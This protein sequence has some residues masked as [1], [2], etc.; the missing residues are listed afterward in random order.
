AI[1]IL[2]SPDI[3]SITPTQRA[4]GVTGSTITVYGSGAYFQSGLS[5]WFSTF[6]SMEAGDADSEVTV[7]AGNI[8]DADASVIYLRDVDVTG[9]AQ[10]GNR[11]LI[12]ENPD[13]GKSITLSSVLTVEP[14]L[15]LTAQGI[16]VV[17]SATDN[18]LGQNVT[19]KTI[20]VTGAGFENGISDSDIS[21]DV[22]TSSINVKSV[23]WKSG[24][25]IELLVDVS[26]LCP[27]GVT[28]LTVTNPDNG[29]TASL[30]AADYF[31]VGAMPLISQITSPA[32]K[33]YGQLAD[34]DGYPAK[35]FTVEGTGF[36]SGME[37][38][39]EDTLITVSNELF[40]GTT[41]YE[42]D[43]IIGSNFSPAEEGGSLV[44]VT[45]VNP[46]LGQ[47]VLSSTITINP[48]PVFTSLDVTSGGQGA[49]GSTLT[50]TGTGL[51]SGAE[52]DFGVGVSTYNAYYHSSSSFTV[53]VDISATAATGKRNV[54][55]R[56]PDLG[57]GVKTSYFDVKNSPDVDYVS[58]A[59][60]APGVS[61]STITV[62]GD[63]A[64]FQS[65]YDAWFSTSSTG[66]PADGEI[67]IENKDFTSVSYVELQ[68]VNITGSALLGDRYIVV[69][70]P[71]GGRSVSALS[72]L[73]IQALPTLT[74]SGISVVGS[75]SSNQLGQNTTEKTIKITGTG[76]ENGIG[77]SDITFDVTSDSITIQSVTWKSSGLL[78][79][80]LDVS[81]G[82]PV[83]NR[84]VTV[85]NPLSGGSDSRGDAGYF[86][87]GAMPV[88][89]TITLPVL[90]EYGQTANTVNYPLKKFTMQGSGFISDLKL[91]FGLNEITQN[92]ALVTGDTQF[93][94]DLTIDSNFSPS[95]S[96]VN[97]RIVNPD[98]GEYT[99]PSAMI[100]N[101]K[102]VF[103]S[104]SVIKAGQGTQGITIVV[105][106]SALQENAT[107]DF[108]VGISTSGAGYDYTDIPS[109]FTVTVDLS[110]SVIV[111]QKDVT[112]RNPDLGYATKT[113][114]F[115]ITGKPEVDTVTPAKRA[116][117]VSG[118]TITV[119]GN[120][121]YFQTGFDIW[122]STDSSGYPADTKI[123]TGTLNGFTASSF[124]LLDFN[125]EADAQLGDRYMAV[126]NPDGGLYVTVSKAMEI[127]AAPTLTA[128]GLVVNGATPPN[129]LGQNV[130]NI[131]LSINGSGFESN[132]E[133]DTSAVYFDVIAP[134]ITVVNV[135][136]I[137]S[138]LIDVYVDVSSNCELGDRTVYVENPDSGG[139][140]SMSDAG[141]FTIG[142][143]P[144]IST[145]TLP[146]LKEY[147]QKADTAG[148][149]AKRFTVE[150]TGFVSNLKL[151]FGSYEITQ[152]DPQ[153]LNGGTTFYC[154]LTIDSNMLVGAKDVKIV[155]PD[156]G[157][158]VL[159][160]AITINTK[161]VLTS[162]SPAYLGQGA[163]NEQIIVVCSS[164]NFQS[165][166]TLSFPDISPTQYSFHTYDY[167][168]GVSSFT[169]LLN[170]DLDA[171]SGL[172]NVRLDNPDLGWSS[173][174]NGFDVRKNPTVASIT[175]SDV[176][177]G[178][179]T[180][181][182][183][184]RTIDIWGVE[185]GVF[186]E[187][188]LV[189]IS[190]DNMA[191]PLDT[192]IIV[193]TV[194]YIG[195]NHLEMDLIVLT[196][197]AWSPGGTPDRYLKL[198]NPDGGYYISG[199]KLLTVNKPPVL[200]TVN[201]GTPNNNDLGQ[202]A[203]D[204]SIR[205]E[206][207]DFQS[208]ATVEINSDVDIHVSNI[209]FDDPD[210]LFDVD[211]DDNAA[212]NASTFTV[213]N[214]DGG[215]S[216]K[217]DYSM[218]HVTTKP[219]VTAVTSPS[220]E[221]YGQGAIDAIILVSGSD[222]IDGIGT[223][224]V[225]FSGT[226]ITL[227]GVSVTPT[228]LT[229][230]VDI[231]ETSAPV[232]SSRTIT[233]INPDFGADVSD[234]PIF[235][236][237]LNPDI[238]SI[239]P[240]TRGQGGQD[241]EL[242]LFGSSFQQGLTVTPTHIDDDIW[243]SGS[244]I[245]I[246]SVTHI[247]VDGS[248]VTVTINITDNASTS[249][250]RSITVRNPDKGRNTFNVGTFVG[251]KPTVGTLDI[252]EL[253]AGA[254]VT[255]ITVSGTGFAAGAQA[256]FTTD[257]GGS[258]EET[259]ITIDSVSGSGEELYLNT[260][261]V[262][263]ACLGAKFLKVINPDGGTDVSDNTVLTVS[264]AP[265][266][267]TVSPTKLGQQAASRDITISGTNFDINTTISDVTFIP[268]E[269]ITKNSIDATNAEDPGNNR[270]IVNVSV[271]SDAA[272]GARDV[273]IINPN[274][275]SNTKAGGLE[276]TSKPTFSMASPSSLGRGA[277]FEDI[278]IT[279]ANFANGMQVYFSGGSGI[280]PNPA[281]A[282]GSATSMSITVSV[283]TDATVTSDWGIKVENTDFG[284]DLVSSTFTVTQRPSVTQLIP[285][286][287]GPG[288][289]AQDILVKG[290]NFQSGL[291]ATD[292]TFSHGGGGISVTDIFYHGVSSFT[293]RINVSQ[294]C[295]TSLGNI[296]IENPDKG[297]ITETDVFTVNDKPVV[298]SCTPSERSKDL[299]NQTIIITG[300]GF[301]IA[302]SVTRAV[303]FGTTSVQAV[304]A[305]NYLNDTTLE[306][307][308]TIYS[309]AGAQG[310]D[311]TVVN[312]DGGVG[313]GSSIFTVN[314]KPSITSLNLPARGQGA[315]NQDIRVNGSD[316]QSGSTVTISGTGVNFTSTTF[317]SANQL[318]IIVNIDYDATISTRDVS[319]L[320][321]DAGTFIF[322]SS[323][324]VHD[325]PVTS[326]GA[327]WLQF[328]NTDL[329]ES[330]GT[331][332]TDSQS[333]SI[334]IRQLSDG[335]WY[336]QGVGFTESSEEWLNADY[337]V[338]DSTWSYTLPGLTDGTSYYVRTF[339]T[340]QNAGREQAGSGVTF[341]HDISEPSAAVT[342]PVHLDHYNASNNKL[343]SLEGTA[344]ADTDYVE[345]SI[346]DITRGTTY[347]D[348]AA[349]IT[350]GADYY[351][352][353]ND[354]TPES[355]SY[356]FSTENWTNAN[357]Y[358]I[359]AQAIDIAGNT[360][361][362]DSKDFWIDYEYPV[363][364]VTI[365]SA[366][367]FNNFTVF[368][369]P[370]YDALPDQESTT[371]SDVEIYIF[372]KADSHYFDETDWDAA[373]AVWIPIPSEN[374]DQDSWSYDVP[375]PTTTFTD[376]YGNDDYDIKVR[377]IDKAVNKECSD[378][379][380]SKTEKVTITWDD[381]PPQ[382]S[383]D[384]PEEADSINYATMT[385]SG[386]VTELNGVDYIALSIYN[387][388]TVQWWTGGGWTG[389][390]Q[391][392]QV[393]PAQ[394]F[395][396]SWTYSGVT[397][398]SG[399]YV[400]QTKGKDLIGPDDNIETPS[401]GR[402]F[403]FDATSP[404]TNSVTIPVHGDWYNDTMASYSG[405]AVDDKSGIQ[406]VKL[407]IQ[408]LTRG[409]TFWNGSNWV[410]DAAENTFGLIGAPYNPWTYSGAEFPT[411]IDNHTYEITPIAKDN[412]GNQ[413]TGSAYRY[414]YDLNTP[415]SSITF[416]QDGGKYG[417]IATITGE[418]YDK[419]ID[420]DSIDKVEVEIYNIDT[421][422]YFQGGASWLNS[423][424][425]L[426]A[427]LGTW[428]STYTLRNWSYSMPTLSDDDNY[429]I[430]SRAQ[431]KSG[432]Y[433]VA[434]D[435]V[436]FLYSAAVPVSI[437]TMPKD[438]AIFYRDIPLARGESHAGSG[439]SVTKVEID[440][441][442]VEDETYKHWNWGDTQWETTTYSD[443]YWTECSY[444]ASNKE[445][446]E[447]DLSVVN[448][449]QVADDK[450]IVIRVRAT[451][452][453]DTESAG[454]GVSVTN[455]ADDDYALSWIK[456]ASLSHGNVE[457]V[458][459]TITVSGI[460]LLPT[461]G[462]LAIQKI[463]PSGN[464]GDTYDLNVDDVYWQW[465]PET[466]IATKD[467]A[468]GT[469]SGD[470]GDWQFELDVSS[471]G[472]GVDWESDKYYR[473]LSK[474]TNAQG[475]ESHHAGTVII[476]D[477]EGPDSHVSAALNGTSFKDLDSISG[478]AQDAVSGVTTDGVEVQVK[479]LLA[480][481]TYYWDGG[482]V[483]FSSTTSNQWNTGTTA[484]A[485][486][487]VTANWSYVSSGVNWG[488]ATV[489]TLLSRAIDKGNNYQTAINAGP[490]VTC[491]R[492]GPSS[493]V[494]YPTTGK[495]LNFIGISDFTVSGSA[496]D[497]LSTVSSA[498]IRVFRNGSYLQ[499]NF[500]WNAADNWIPASG[501]TDWSVDL[502]TDVWT[503]DLVSTITARATDN[504][505]NI[506]AES[507]PVWF[508]Y[509]DEAPVSN[510]NKPDGVHNYNDTVSDITDYIH[511]DV[512]DNNTYDKVYVRIQ[513]GVLD[514]YWDDVADD[515]LSGSEHWNEVEIHQS[516][517][518]YT[519]L[520]TWLNQWNY[521]VW[522][523]AVDIAS[524]VEAAGSYNQF[525]F[526]N[527]D[528]ESRITS[529]SASSFTGTPPNIAGTSEDLETGIKD[530][531]I[532]LKY[533]DS[534]T[535][536]YWNTV[537]WDT[538]VEWMNSDDPSVSP[539]S[540]SGEPD[541]TDLE[542]GR[543]YK[544]VSQAADTKGPEAPPTGNLNMEDYSANWVDF[545]WDI[546][547]PTAVVT[548]PANNG[549]IP[550]INDISGTCFDITGATYSVPGV[551]T[552]S[553][554]VAEVQL[555]LWKLI[556]ST[557]Y[558]W[559][560]FAMQPNTWTVAVAWSTA[561]LS[562]DATSWILPHPVWETKEYKVVVRARDAGDNYQVLVNTITFK[563]DFINPESY[564]TNPVD[565]TKYESMNTITGTASDE[566][567]LEKIKIKIVND[568]GGDDR[569][570]YCW[571][572]ITWT[573]TNPYWV[574]A[575]FTDWPDWSYTID[576]PT[577]AWEHGKYYEVFTHAVDKANNEETTEE[578]TRNENRFL[579]NDQASSFRVTIET[580]PVAGV[581][582]TMTVDAWDNVNNNVA[583]AYRGT[584][585]FRSPSGMNFTMT[586]GT[587]TFVEGDNGSHTFSVGISSGPLFRTPEGAGTFE[588]YDDE[589]YAGEISSMVA[590]NLIPNDLNHFD[591]T[592][593]PSQVTAGTEYDITVTARDVYNN[594]K[595]N[596][597]GFV[598]FAS[599][600]PL[601]TFKDNY[602]FI[603]G[604]AGE[605]LFPSTV[606]MRT[607]NVGPGNGST[608]WW[609]R[610]RD[611]GENVE[612]YA[613]N[614]T[615]YPKSY[616]AF[617]VSV[618]TGPLTA[619][620]ATDIIVEAIDDYG[621]RCSTGSVI[622]D[623][624]VEF[625]SSDGSAV[626]PDDYTFTT[627]SGNDNG[628]H[629]FTSSLTL[630]TVGTHWFKANDTIATGKSG[631]QN[632]IEVDPATRT[633][634]ELIMSTDQT[635]GIAFSI[636]VMAKDQYGNID[637]NN[638]DFVQFVTNNT[639]ATLPLISEQLVSGEK[640]WLNSF[641]LRAA[642]WTLAGVLTQPW[643]IE[644]QWENNPGVINGRKENI[645]ITP[646]PASEFV[647]S[648]VADPIGAGDP[649]A[650]FVEA[651][652]EYGNR[653]V[654]YI[655]T[656]T[657]TSDSPSW[658][659]V[660]A[661]YTFL[662]SDRG[663]K[664]FSATFN[665]ASP[666]DY[667]LE[668]Y[669][670]IPSSPTLNGQFPGITVN[671]S[672]FT[673]LTITGIDDPETEGHISQSVIVTARDQFNNVYTSY[674]STVSFS[675]LTDPG[676]TASPSQYWYQPGD[677]GIHTFNITMTEPGEHDV[678]VYD[679]ITPAKDGYQYNVTVTTKPL[680]NRTQP[681]SAQSSFPYYK[682]LTQVQ[683]T[684]F[685]YDPAQISTVN[686]RIYD[687]TEN[688]YWDEIQT[689]WTGNEYWNLTTGTTEWIYNTA[690]WPSQGDYKINTVAYDDLTGDETLA[691]TTTT[692]TF[693][694]VRPNTIIENPG[695]GGDYQYID[696]FSGTSNDASSPMDEV[697]IQIQ[698]ITR[699]TT[700]WD[701]DNS[702]W[703]TS[704]LWIDKNSVQAVLGA[705]DWQWNSSLVGWMDQHQY[706]IT[707]QAKDQAGNWDDLTPAISN[708]TIDEDSP[709][710]SVA[711][712]V[713]GRNYYSIP[714]L[715]GAASDTQGINRVRIMIVRDS[716]GFY[717]DPSAGTWDFINSFT[718]FTVSGQDSW[719]WNS[720][721]VTFVD[722]ITYKVKSI[723]IDEAENTENYVP[724]GFN[725]FIF[726]TDEST[727]AV[728]SPSISNVNTA[729]GAF[730]VS[731]TAG[732][733]DSDV[734]G[735]QIV[736]KRDQGAGSYWD[737]QQDDWV[738]GIYWNNITGTDT[739]SYPDDP[740][741]DGIQLVDGV[742]HRIWTRSWDNA[743]PGGTTEQVL[744]GDIDTN[745]NEKQSF[746]Y[747]ITK[748]SSSITYPVDTAA[749]NIQIETFTGS[750][751]D[752]KTGGLQ[753]SEV[754]EVRLR[755]KRK[756]DG[757]YWQHPGWGAADSLATVEDV[758]PGTETFEWY[759]T[760]AN[761]GAVYSAQTETY[762]I[763]VKAKD[764]ADNYESGA[765]W[766]NVH[767]SSATERKATF[768]YDMIAPAIS[769]STP[770][771][772]SHHNQLTEIG[773]ISS[774]GYSGVNNVKVNISSGAYSWTGS[775]WTSNTEW[776]TATGTATWK[777]T[778]LTDA[779]I[780]NNKYM[781]TGRVWDNASNFTSAIS[782]FV[783]DVNE[784]TASVVVP[785]SGEP[786]YTTETLPAFFTGNS[787]DTAP[788]QPQNTIVALENI[789]AGKY[790]NGT[791]W[792]GG[793]TWSNE[794]GT[795]D[796][797]TGAA[798]WQWATSDIT[799]WNDPT[800]N[801]KHVFYAKAI[802]EAGNE[803]LDVNIS[804]NIFWFQGDLP[805][806]I[807]TKP[808][809][810]NH[811]NWAANGLLSIE[812]TYEFCDEV[813]IRIYRNND[814]QCW[815]QTGKV[816]VSSDT[817]E[818]W[819]VKSVADDEWT[820]SIDTTAW[821]SGDTYLV[822]SR[823]WAPTMGNE[824][825]YLIKAQTNKNITID[826]QN[827][828][829]SVTSPENGSFLNSASEID[830][831][832]SDLLAGIRD[833]TVSLQDDS[834][835]KY[836]D[837]T[838]DDW[839]DP[840]AWSTTVYVAGNWSFV[841][842]PSL[843]QGQLYRIKPKARDDI[844]EG[845]GNFNE[846]IGSEITFTYDIVAPTV[847]ITSPADSSFPSAISTMTGTSTD[848][849]PIELIKLQ[850]KN[851]DATT[852]WKPG[853]GGGWST[854]EKWVTAAGT[855]PWTYDATPIGFLEGVD[856][857]LTA[858]AI[859]EA[860]STSTIITNNFT[861]DD[862]EPNSVI[863][864]PADAYLTDTDL[865]INGIYGNASDNVSGIDDD[866]V[867]NTLYDIT[868]DSYWNG[869]TWQ[870][871]VSTLT[872]SLQWEADYILP[873]MW[874]SAHK[875]TIT[876]WVS[877]DKAIPGNVQ[878]SP[879]TFEVVVDSVPPVSRTTTPSDG[880][881][882][883]ALSLIEGTCYDDWASV[884]NDWAANPME[885]EIKALANAPAG[886]DDNEYWKGSTLEWTTY[887]AVAFPDVYISSWSYN[888]TGSL[889]SGREY[890][891]V[892]SMTDRV[893][894]TQIDI[895][896]VTVLI[897]TD[898]P[899]SSFQEPIDPTNGNYFNDI[900]QIT[901]ITQDEP[902]APSNRSGLSLIELQLID[903]TDSM[904]WEGST[905]TAVN[906]WVPA[907]DL[908][909]W[910]YNIDTQTDTWENNHD[911]TF[912]TR[913]L[914]IAGNTESP[915]GDLSL[916]F[917]DENPVSAVT[918]PFDG[919]YV[920][921][922]LSITSGTISDNK[923]GV[924]YVEVWIQ[925]VEGNYYKAADN[926]FTSGVKVWNPVDT[927]PGDS[928]WSLTVATDVWTDGASYIVQSMAYDAAT[929]VDGNSPN[930]E[931]AVA[932]ITFIY[933]ESNPESEVVY[934]STENHTIYTN[935]TPQIIGT[936][937]DNAPG[938]IKT[939]KYSIKRQDTKYWDGEDW[940]SGSEVWVDADATSADF[941][942]WKATA[943]DWVKDV[944]YEVKSKAYDDADN[945]E[946]AFM[947]TVSSFVYDTELPTSTP[948]SPVDE[949]YVDVLTD[950]S[951]TAA[952]SGGS[953]VRTVRTLIIDI[954][955]A[956]T[957][958]WSG[959]ALDWQDTE[960][961]PWPLA[962]GK[963]SW[964]YSDFADSDMTDGHRYEIKVKAQD[965]ATNEQV[966]TIQ[967]F[968]YDKA[969]PVSKVTIPVN[970]FY[971]ELNTISGTAKDTPDS[972]FSAGVN[973][974]D[975]MIADRTADPDDYWTG[976]EWSTSTIDF[977]AAAGSTTWT[978]DASG[979]GL[980]WTDAHVYDVIPR[981]TDQT[982]NVEQSFSTVTFT[983]DDSDPT[984]VITN[985]QTADETKIQ[986]I[987]EGTAS[988]TPAQVTAVEIKIEDRT[989]VGDYW[990]GST[991]T[992]SV[993]WLP[994]NYTG[995]GWDY[996]IV[997]TDT[998][999]DGHLYKIQSRAY[1000]ES[1001]NVED[1002]GTSGNSFTYDITKPQSAQITIQNN[1003]YEKYLDQITGSSTDEK[1004][1005]V[1006]EARVLVE[1007]DDIPELYW[1008][1009]PGKVWDTDPVWNLV[1010]A[1011]NAPF[1012][1013]NDEDWTIA[1014]A[1015]YAWISGGRVS[1016]ES[1017]RVYTRATDDSTNEET[1018]G[1019][1020]VYFT[1021]DE[1022]EP[1023]SI[1024]TD[1025]ADGNTY[1026]QITA[1027]GG[1028][1029]N[1030]DETFVS[1031]V[1032]ISIYDQ[1033]S[1034]LYS[1035]GAGGWGGSVD[1036]LNT[1037][1038]YTS[1039]WTFAA[1040]ALTSDHNYRIVSRA[1041]DAALNFETTLSTIIF[1042]YDDEAPTS[1043]ITSPSAG[1044][1045]NS[1046]SSIVGNS[1047]DT[1048][1049]GIALAQLRIQ[1050]ITAGTSY[1051]T[1052]VAWSTTSVWQDAIGD[1053]SWT[1054]NNVPDWI[1055]GHQVT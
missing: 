481:D 406:E 140:V 310:Y 305:V 1005:G 763:E 704:A 562:G 172:R 621:N 370:I 979:A 467:W 767:W 556:G 380:S 83:G 623:D 600:E 464:D 595:T 1016:G 1049:S 45:L 210:I 14:E 599:N 753:N 945:E 493:T 855:D 232:I 500:T 692:F 100:I 1029:F 875:Y 831:D 592:S 429:R 705:A 594:K 327:P 755:I 717:F 361:D 463:T 612:K 943:T 113:D 892:S 955:G 274:Y 567:E 634:Y 184:V 398:E 601:A 118:S 883:K 460:G 826:N 452:T 5:V 279:G 355:W 1013:S 237:N 817:A 319:V 86:V 1028:T 134:S 212:I 822:T 958:Y 428:I 969:K 479:Y 417:G 419:P 225:E 171:D 226:G 561:T 873:G 427:A 246:S 1024:I 351:F 304:S 962:A 960:P 92:N 385:L 680:S 400:V 421:G 609:I 277:T 144:L 426:E 606:T 320:N 993:I 325:N 851:K 799:L 716:D 559:D 205:I 982:G 98:F 523:Y 898:D 505:T 912:K 935:I 536:Y 223:D 316:F 1054:Y 814:D 941:T 524:N 786:N 887:T 59:V 217:S 572:G 491:D 1033:N 526:D 311:V 968:Y 663:K 648:G 438:G 811:Y 697:K 775:S 240:T 1015:S 537:N 675:C 906:T 750:F 880:N 148:N 384:F 446:W 282:A 10:L 756:S 142:Q 196:T 63:G 708:I 115:E 259:L 510:V 430:V 1052:G 302:G 317:I 527:M 473:I 722:G 821:D 368:S 573:V 618:D 254:S 27:T 133:G 996:N 569:Q 913:G 24:S 591:I 399:D 637:T 309:T 920:K 198:V 707:V 829:V 839:D 105:N 978:Y 61:G 626:I 340:G 203:S 854:S 660:F 331:A 390:Q 363:S 93:E 365:P 801:E 408:N 224:D 734:A 639:D 522:S 732:D 469:I 333:V 590:L 72:V 949:S 803:Q 293:A 934:I 357:K 476:I 696:L 723:A 159:S 781:I 555:K 535:T 667:Y 867:E 20:K 401:A 671:P 664:S 587:Y 987:I 214:P 179:G 1039:S 1025:P 204:I 1050:D 253:G 999:T 541:A 188:C 37:L 589:T 266:I 485:A 394:L 967:H 270:I 174:T 815:D 152:D 33:E 915:S 251:L 798:S 946:S 631:Q 116:R 23:T 3:N 162:L 583:T 539:W 91:Y 287:L 861:F 564:L 177:R 486:G 231:A 121:P 674:D 794:S 48:K 848:G 379:G 34:T 878:T 1023:D 638:G 402:N 260:V 776:L 584:V 49:V 726:D 872:T 932:S 403:S 88:I 691:Y 369:G 285:N 603:L 1022:I 119:I 702:T 668:A 1042:T 930:V 296:T 373:S 272:T 412:S 652:D 99:L 769:M 748:P 1009:E 97:V 252:D 850:I 905:W 187:G 543:I 764:N 336:K 761:L 800:V 189:Y 247:A 405:A 693:D 420:K 809:N 447:K 62:Y 642:S 128:S 627:G 267:N 547:V 60:R 457:S 236:V 879:D 53:Q 890:V 306:V 513:K 32:V 770:I 308:V 381:T 208:G 593:L 299:A 863:I 921:P 923:S 18:E 835:S 759:V 538:P 806:S 640:E 919:Q 145:I 749:Y 337:V 284:Y 529:P 843:T 138:G 777:Y 931:V 820:I 395:Q 353:I 178:A 565:N 783:Y 725:T 345:I 40:D 207:D 480:G 436:T 19:D 602:T 220:P 475:T 216:S 81:S 737:D 386:S 453:G 816:W 191:S 418:V 95:A 644:A 662:A 249:T 69:E 180:Q 742:V 889:D 354:P 971:K 910:Y 582:Y 884:N 206:G 12:V 435:T 893:P 976:T 153:V 201:T 682:A 860:G 607:A 372:R 422:N 548:Y 489:Y 532:Q 531:K 67:T 706:N 352:D 954:T 482:A 393:P 502:P 461:S 85:T 51:Q 300:S 41:Y 307:D 981:A 297:I 321:P 139:I 868:D 143:M 795:F 197:A 127:V 937:S 972:L 448:F 364:T 560:N 110:D 71:D 840:I 1036:W 181:G 516:S 490:T 635:A 655:S 367:V 646:K 186:Q 715:S 511:G 933:D 64:Y 156:L 42:C 845:N 728:I 250:V 709:L 842:M 673:D 802:D 512:S 1043:N 507:S 458:I 478:T 936:S 528:P 190:T 927:T 338:A 494:E 520:P 415:T 918:A 342:K 683:G 8:D 886:W 985:P 404:V 948:T 632:G 75:A 182:T 540:V 530:V 804:S 557:S 922:Q 387:S 549:Y 66:L 233:V 900:A 149:S 757:S 926:G 125:V 243:F 570:N 326:I 991:W 126:L 944:I 614:I 911:Y 112:L 616:S 515:W 109:S 193:D 990:N 876:S 318:Q 812:G 1017:Y 677:A 542:T 137:N 645:M 760:Q 796:E 378:D 508:M 714:Q 657:F 397:W 514:A 853:P 9:S 117:G 443:F 269:N 909:S 939:V 651:R 79:V 471:N 94:C 574:E 874:T 751:N 262:L 1032:T 964:T 792:V 383:V 255:K 553:G 653:E 358:N 780:G 689:I 199:T 1047:T 665:T 808:V 940:D 350:S 807:I 654:N 444:P 382:S 834:N 503:N 431:D 106:G 388:D 56:N 782:T 82:C 837:V 238:T 151:Y 710:S 57:Y 280:T 1012:D 823:G 29:G 1027:I 141:Y 643:Y 699:G 4:Q 575:D 488:N 168:Y 239:S 844:N 588:V 30:G 90:K 847:S 334:S 349:W 929:D 902:S 242:S 988:G 1031:S 1038:L 278:T 824:A 694:S 107:V 265:A 2:N 6:S 928:S 163:S 894:N 739:W 200:T 836:W 194:T 440:V 585:K 908:A 772:L 339:G 235:K 103:S 622:Y 882:L 1034:T 154:D 227:D 744:A 580:N 768:I 957:Y 195:S 713:N 735:M 160:N 1051:W 313:I 136:W 1003:T 766:T 727:S 55:L 343:D 738:A 244:G 155:N 241:V 77:S 87:I 983:Y 245:E 733:D 434:Y 273:K 1048:T 114:Y 276:I 70:N 519:D 558:Y 1044:L 290:S 758:A 221:Q 294:T 827:P 628:Y 989:V 797:P 617:N 54:T 891:I 604:D 534:G 984:S 130:S 597:T 1018:V 487:G 39:F 25:L 961:D 132:M 258:T 359:K 292:V 26:S 610:V 828:S 790:W 474:A 1046:L 165:G 495:L 131:K 470:P 371:V 366:G 509:D 791:G 161:P 649:D 711:V 1004:T 865:E 745:Q 7:D 950:I 1002:P 563:G 465:G 862:G 718:T 449:S 47:V 275:G 729:T 459:S 859:D 164:S 248:S 17:G 414:Y 888:F 1007:L 613:N 810:N 11:W 424:K 678:K 497:V 286:N 230:T 68:D 679:I 1:N 1030:D 659:V 344:P 578:Q 647:V 620:T 571:N 120:G 899:V 416:P 257:A 263:P 101:P 1019:A 869:G 1026:S 550:A 877:Q 202:G 175:P 903:E 332:T 825:D 521:R 1053:T 301:D 740:A 209:T 1020:G 577:V 743:L 411:H 425:W 219:T 74:A 129:Q 995:P 13:G 362:E 856:Y 846:T 329:A 234:I 670:S 410:N 819:N 907:V 439:Y 391:W 700:Y 633:N 315:Q 498:E 568:T 445:Y 566:N 462:Q 22:G 778:S 1021:Y 608:P 80:L 994:V 111:G 953:D 73:E 451:S 185:A 335:L 576:S 554:S 963:N 785:A 283:S 173:K 450:S 904:Y 973:N 50:V 818:A 1041:V 170:I 841:N 771:H 959:S 986:D 832:A 629:T 492:L 852:W 741:A 1014:I 866:V 624:T 323:F 229:L 762:Y 21:F 552:S 1006:A 38:Y 881:D 213:T 157:E 46:N 346:K 322:N 947:I 147:G 747:D 135:D 506:G 433:D 997:S 504:L 1011:D 788:G 698:D 1008:D 789:T 328:H 721:T 779:W 295:D 348:G 736:I 389:S 78:D 218:F 998:W 813:H 375:D 765:G 545:T 598:E 360:G 669:Q 96:T 176:A 58:P 942:S 15:T 146:V 484:G 442:H 314:N 52:L 656:I 312:P 167:N 917:D 377:T 773:G 720:S 36:E 303:S 838:L 992:A 89:S 579:F 432:Y 35:K 977:F 123:D 124:E 551:I 228:Q 546:N 271:S 84:T 518:T 974:I 466:W 701:T 291:D 625:T 396:T 183:P 703:T 970:N 596:Y 870:P 980:T 925:K 211:V 456:L 1037:V 533:I 658:S 730:T 289:A 374:F 44:D 731:G 774:D 347:W 392:P 477:T 169:A 650:F 895:S 31:V 754:D 630:K 501:Q 605:K 1045:Y 1000:D 341:I 719:T 525:Q 544:V 833:V 896:S 864:Y 330:T 871:G 499:D 150:G 256:Y 611:D 108:G 407:K 1035:D 830:G 975:L 641:T 441:T 784:P 681:S 857:S 581:Q 16:T 76:F 468:T 885:L 916:S 1055:T 517:W 43:I 1010:T 724:K 158:Y 455:D 956:T 264:P 288:A 324:D 914:D 192:T 496:N 938:Q 752:L 849:F 684:A 437:I 897:D 166:A 712:P 356:S 901:G 454:T 666:P 858:K 222:F 924:D 268:P 483:E 261:S 413:D 690:S 676:F 695:T 672:G 409:T 619:G 687:V 615:C 298:T 965:K 685:S 688:K 376:Q 102:P 586:P 636:T 787:T 661:T 951:G 686:I 281:G 1001:N 104:L 952:D 805:V 793:I 215:T 28:T 746:L 423:P 472:W 966:G 122:F 1040:P 65:G